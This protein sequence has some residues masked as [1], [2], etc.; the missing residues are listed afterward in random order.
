VIYDI[1]GQEI[2]FGKRL[3]NDL[4]CV[5]WDAKPQL[6]QSINLSSGVS[7]VVDD[8]AVRPLVVVMNALSKV[9]CSV[10]R[11]RWPGGA[12]QEPLR[13]HVLQLEEE[14]HELKTQVDLE[15]NR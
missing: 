4:F 10:L 6:N 14:N 13:L 9:S 1:P 2:G 3:Q 8:E 15:N 12:E 7:P 11:L 5:N